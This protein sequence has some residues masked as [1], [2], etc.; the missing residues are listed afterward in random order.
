[1]RGSPF[2]LQ[3]WQSG[4]EK[5][6]QAL[7]GDRDGCGYSMGRPS[8]LRPEQPPARAH[9]CD[10]SFIIGELYHRPGVRR[11]RRVRAVLIAWDIARVHWMRV[12]GSDGALS[13][14]DIRIDRAGRRCG[15]RGGLASA[16]S[17][18]PLGCAR[19][20]CRAGLADAVSP[21]SVGSGAGPM[22]RCVGA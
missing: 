12:I 20:A 3:R 22:P 10:A 6:G 9:R 8:L 19:S 1:M 7:T 21:V 14:M 13:G 4:R 16:L 5:L 2:R 15:A 17:L 11:P 18:Q